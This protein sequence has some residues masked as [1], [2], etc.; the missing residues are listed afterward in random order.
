M[1]RAASPAAVLFDLD[2]TLADTAPDL[3]GA[4]E[5]LRV[6]LGLPVIDTSPLR[7]VASRGAVA[8]LERGLPELDE[9]AREAVRGRYLDDY[10]GR[11]WEAS[12]P[13]EGIPELLDSLEA[14]GIP[15]GIVTNKLEGLARPVVEGAGWTSRVGC[16]VGGDTAARPK[17]AADPVLAACR[18]LG[19]DPAGSVFVGDDER[20]VLAGRAAGTATVAASWGYIPEGVQVA[21][22]GA[23]AIVETPAEISGRFGL[24]SARAAV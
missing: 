4:L 20:D 9:Q 3:I 6:R 18:A 1:S 17:P 11:C 8:I 19:V 10:R 15:W 5:R 12:R 21:E 22:W 14:A 7:N 16:L 23:D 2:G 24:N 13:F